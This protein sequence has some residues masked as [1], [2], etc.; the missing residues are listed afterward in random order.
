MIPFKFANKESDAKNLEGLFLLCFKMISF[1][2][3][4]FEFE[5]PPIEILNKQ[6]ISV[7]LVS[8]LGYPQVSSKFYGNELRVIFDSALLDDL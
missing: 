7:C 6:R 4:K 2:Q 3:L 1:F 8:R 5:I